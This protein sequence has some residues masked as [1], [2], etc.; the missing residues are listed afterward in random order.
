MSFSL[1][2]HIP[3]CLVK[4]PYCDFNAYGV[5]TWPEQE[6]VEALCAELRFYATQAP[7]CGESIATIYFGGGTPSLFAPASI[8]HFLEV[9]TESFPLVPASEITLEAD[10]AS[11]T[12]ETLAGFRAAGVN[13]LSF[14]VQSFQ[15]RLLKTLGR[16]H[17]AEDGPRVLAWAR[18]AGFTNLTMDLIFGVPGQTLAL[19]ADDLQQTLVAAPEHVSLYNLTYEEGT[20]FFERKRQGKLHPVDEDEEVAMFSYIRET[21]LAQGYRH[22]EISNFARLGCTSRH[23]ANYWQGGNYLGLGAGAHSYSQ[24]PGW[25]LRWSNERKPNAYMRKAVAGGS[26]LDSQEQLT[27]TQARGE[28]LFLH[29]RQLEGFALGTF[30]ERFGVPL[31]EA[32]PHLG[33][34]AA[35]G[36]VREESGRL[37]LTPKGLLMADTIFASFV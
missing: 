31:A 22:Y 5:K 9:V 26:A 36:L 17:T 20:P 34:L 19:L 12:R 33:D 28:F 2:V 25:G 35:E 23:N 37:A 11:I 10:P 32:F 1:Y 29:L 3:Y 18:E 8:A 21:L 24:A 14:G 4:C 15:P 30:A 16:L 27:Y 7:W 13:R 6:Y